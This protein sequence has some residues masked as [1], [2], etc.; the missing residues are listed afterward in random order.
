M[1]LGALYQIVTSRLAHAGEDPTATHLLSMAVCALLFS[2][3]AP[4]S[5]SPVDSMASWGWLALMSATGAAGHLFVA[6]ASLGAVF[7]VSPHGEPLARI[8]SCRGRTTTN[9]A[10]TPDGHSLVI[11]ESATGTILRARWTPPPHD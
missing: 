11:T 8:A 5:W 9:V 6:H 1:V 4:L 10:L 3:T 7:V 2:L